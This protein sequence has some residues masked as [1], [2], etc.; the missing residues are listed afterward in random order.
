[1][2]IPSPGVKFHNTKDRLESDIITSCCRNKHPN[3]RGSR[4]HTTSIQKPETLGLERSYASVDKSCNCRAFQRRLD[5]RCVPLYGSIVRNP[6]NIHKPAAFSRLEQNL[7][8]RNIF[9][10]NRNLRRAYRKQLGMVLGQNFC[11]R[12]M[13]SSGNN[14]ARQRVLD[15][16]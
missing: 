15:K 13:D 16:G 10:N 4:M 6:G 14:A 8:I 11:P 3:N 2:F 9:C 1:M 5:L 7:C 12:K